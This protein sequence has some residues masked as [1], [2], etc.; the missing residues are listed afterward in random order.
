MRTAPSSS[1]QELLARA[2]DRLLDP[3]GRALAAAVQWWTLP[4]L[5]DGPW[6]VAIVG[7]GPPVLTLHGFDSSHLEFRRLAPLLAPT[8]QL[9][10]PDLFGF[11]F[12]P[13]PLD[14]SYGPEAVLDHLEQVL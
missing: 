4:D 8:H 9:F 14:A 5:P 11:G 2:A 13:R 6:P 1:G 3:D 10:I 12:C 7:E